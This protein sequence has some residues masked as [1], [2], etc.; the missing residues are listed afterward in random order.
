MI[1]PGTV[2]RPVLESR[3][4]RGNPL[5]DPADRVTP[6]YLPPSYNDHPARRYPLIL[7]L[8]GFTG[9]GRMLLNESFLDESLSQRLDRLIGDAA[10]GEAIV[11]MPDCMTRYGGSQYLDSPATGSYA[12]YLMDEVIAWADRL[13]R[14]IPAREARGVFG[15]SSGGYGA[16][17]FAMDYPD[18]ISA[19][20][21]HSGDMAFEYCYLPEF[22]EALR[23]FW[24]NNLTPKQFC[25]TFRSLPIKGSGFHAT[26]NE[27]AMASCYSPNA[28]AETGFDL[29]FDLETGEIVPDVWDRWL[30]NDPVRMIPSKLDALRSQ[31]LVFLDCGT[32]DEVLLDIG[33]R[34]AS[35]MLREAGI[36]VIHEEFNDGHRNIPYRYDRSLPLLTGV[37][38]KTDG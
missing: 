36:P 23:Y 8:T 26:L 7:A 17:R 15:K 6:V 4:L 11:V 33:A 19:F 3:V 29:P 35:K 28:D 18:V 22:P 21:C 27:L 34:R 37:L 1:S 13:F 9:T 31:R 14:T 25:D 20:A 5:G 24:H 2:L 38:E 32:R 30:V 12:T 16:I 10:M